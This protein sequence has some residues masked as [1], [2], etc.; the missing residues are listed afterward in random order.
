L[1]SYAALDAP[2][3]M[4]L[5]R[6]RA[7]EQPPDVSCV[8]FVYDGYTTEDGVKNDTFFIEAHERGT[9][10][11]FV[12][13]QRYRLEK[14][15]GS[16]VPL[17]ELELLQQGKPMLTEDGEATS[18]VGDVVP[19]RPSVAQPT[20]EWS[21]QTPE[22]ATLDALVL[23]P[24]PRTFSLHYLRKGKVESS[25]T[26]FPGGHLLAV[27]SLLVDDWPV[28]SKALNDALVYVSAGFRV[29]D[30]DKAGTGESI[31]V[32]SPEALGEPPDAGRLQRFLEAICD[33]PDAAYRGRASVVVAPRPSSAGSTRR[34]Q[35]KAHIEQLLS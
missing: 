24:E 32:V 11:S 22:G 23:L 8:A 18:S 7:R 1:E 25:E 15:E 27:R 28:S 14:A 2:K 21:V 4:V 20:V 31:V 33:L 35:A 3:A 13:S 26:R 12:W 19:E 6:K 5:G 16:R 34:E 30:P 10:A 29:V 17:E 9:P